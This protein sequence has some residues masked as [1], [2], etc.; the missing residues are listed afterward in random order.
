MREAHAAKTTSRPVRRIR[1][2]YGLLLCCVALFVIRLFYLQ[3]IRH[4]YYQSAA[5]RGQLKEYE[6]PPERGIIEAQNGESTVP[7]V[8]N[9]TRYTLYADPVYVKDANGAADKLVQAIGGDITG[10]QGEV[11]NCSCVGCICIYD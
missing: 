4:D 8:L 11:K 6:I 9:E 2:W 5:L 3:V 10:T 1:I 7:I